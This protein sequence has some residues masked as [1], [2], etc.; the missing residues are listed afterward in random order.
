MSIN[1]T[2]E[3]EVKTKKGK[4]GAA[5]QI[6]LEGDKQ[7]VEKEIQDINSRHNSL[8][9]KHESLSRTVQGI[10][11]TGGASTATNVTYNNNTSELNAENVQDAI[12]KLVTSL[13]SE[14]SYKGIAKPTTNPGI[15]NNNVFYIAGDGSYPNFGNQVVEIGQIAVL[16]W[17]GS[18]HK[19]VLEIGAGGGNMILDWNTD[20]ATTRKQVPSKYRKAGIQI[21]YKNGEG[22]WV[23]EQYIRTNFTNIEWVKDANW[24]RIPSQSQ[25]SKLENDLTSNLNVSLTQEL[26]WNGSTEI[27]IPDELFI[28]GGVW[29]I[30]S[31]NKAYIFKPATGFYYT[32]P[33]KVPKGTILD[34]NVNINNNNDINASGFIVDKNL[35]VIELNPYMVTVDDAF[36]CFYR[37]DTS[38]KILLKN[39]SQAF[40]LKENEGK[41]IDNLIKYRAYYNSEGVLIKYNYDNVCAT[42]KIPVNKGDVFF[43]DG[44]LNLYAGYGLTKYNADGSRIEGTKDTNYSKYIL[45]ITEDEV[46]FISLCFNKINNYK[47]PICVKITDIN[48]SYIDSLVNTSSQSWQIIKDGFFVSNN[49]STSYV[50]YPRGK[51]LTFPMQITLINDAVFCIENKTPMNNETDYYMIDLEILSAIGKENGE[52]L[53]FNHPAGIGSYV[54]T[55]RLV[56][57][58]K[59]W[60][61]LLTFH[62]NDNSNPTIKIYSI[63]QI[64]GNV[65][66]TSISK[67]TVYCAIGDSITIAYNNYAFRLAKLLSLELTNLAEGGYTLQGQT[68]DKRLAM[69]PDNVGLLTLTCGTNKGFR[70]VDTSLSLIEDIEQNIDSVDKSS[71][72][73]CCNRAINAAR[74]KNKNCK[75][76]LIAPVGDKDE[77]TDKECYWHSL[78]FKAVAE[79]RNCIFVDSRKYIPQTKDTCDIFTNDGR[80]PNSEIYYW[81]TNLILEELQRSTCKN[82]L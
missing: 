81:W 23:N 5:K 13:K 69:I 11:A 56:L 42:E 45:E 9:T 49:S 29:R 48:K 75:V 78:V 72:I 57:I 32:N 35:N 77:E 34:N 60:S 20:V 36:V 15:P 62:V 53:K 8:N 40:L 21:S 46:K 61:N 67:G 80:H 19:E 4:L 38:T 44:G 18:W 39:Y 22:D 31:E 17:D 82:I 37:N 16:K 79:R 74:A 43:L 24:E 26:S 73:G 2:D 28:E 33:I 3:I 41:K 68:S 55:R 54:G 47:I 12:D 10:A 52:V 66:I 58:N 59:T 25:L 1:L 71:T 65:D 27:A 7:N 50:D 70:K 63:T 64:S 6:F 76:V 14:F 51:D 30:N